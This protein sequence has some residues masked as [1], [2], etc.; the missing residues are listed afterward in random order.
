MNSFMGMRVPENATHCVA[1]FL[2]EILEIGVPARFSSKVA[3]WGNCKVM[4]TKKFRL[5]D[6]NVRGRVL[7]ALSATR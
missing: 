5:G 6:V 7:A 4:S 2:T 1:P 3:F